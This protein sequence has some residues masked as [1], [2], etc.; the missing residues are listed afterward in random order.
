M[1][2]EVIHRGDLDAYVSGE[3]SRAEAR[4]VEAHLF[5]CGECAVELRRLRAEQRLFRARAEQEAAEV[6]SFEGVLARIAAGSSAPAAP[7]A[8]WSMPVA[9]DAAPVS[10]TDG[11]AA[12]VAAIGEI[13]ARPA[14]VRAGASGASVRPGSRRG[15]RGAE[16]GLASG[17]AARLAPVGVAAA[18]LAAA[19]ASWVGVRPSPVDEG[20]GARDLAHDVEIGPDRVCADDGEDTDEPLASMPPVRA[21]TIDS[22]PRPGDDR[23]FHEPVSRP[24]EVCSTGDAPSTDACGEA[25]TWCELSR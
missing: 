1:S 16:R 2:C 22:P 18:A 19:A 8:P 20:P 15:T 3:L 13:L 25:V 21:T 11:A 14:P 4:R 12:R 10:A 7:D 6:P 9:P 24:V 5:G 17:W 23:A